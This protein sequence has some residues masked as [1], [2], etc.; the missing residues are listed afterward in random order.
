MICLAYNMGSGFRNNQI[1]YNDVKVE[2][3]DT[4]HRRMSGCFVTMNYILKY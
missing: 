2:T 3:G 1:Y 4:S